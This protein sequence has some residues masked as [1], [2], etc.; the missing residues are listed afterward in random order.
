MRRAGDRYHWLVWRP[1]IACAAED[2]HH[3]T[4]RENPEV[5][6]TRRNVSDR[7]AFTLVELLVVIAVVGVLISILLPAVQAAREAARRMH[8]K[9]NL[10][11]V[12]LAVVAY[13][14]SFKSLPPAGIVSYCNPP[15][16]RRCDGSFDMRPSTP[17]NPLFSWLTQIL[18]QLEEQSLYDRFDFDAGILNQDAANGPQAEVLG[19]LVCPSDRT[20]PRLAKMPDLTGETE[21]GKGNYAGFP[22]PVHCSHGEYVAG[23]LGGFRPGPDVKFGQRLNKIKDGNSKTLL[24]TEVRTRA[25]PTDARGAWALPW[26]GSSL[27]SPDVHPQ[28][29]E[30]Y[31]ILAWKKSVYRPRDD[32]DAEL[33]AQTPNK[34]FHIFDVLFRCDSVASLLEGMP[35]ANYAHSG[36]LGGFW[37][38]APRSLHAG[39]VNVV[40]LDGHVGFMSDDVD[41]VALARMVCVNDGGG[42]EVSDHIR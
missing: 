10:R 16:N 27:V 31:N 1:A 12:G 20:G 38:A 7:G 5:R 37:S 23:A 36:T 2:R 29:L 19:L 8:C 35:C 30:E 39:G 22:S 17:G 6:V 34:Q 28:P 15:I 21:F 11:Q 14:S 42:V 13:E 26:A 25:D 4:I 24:A 32:A 40:V 9:N 3:R 33:S 41:F 18:P